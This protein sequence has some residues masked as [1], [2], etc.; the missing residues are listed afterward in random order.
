MLLAFLVGI[1]LAGCATQGQRLDTART[2]IAAAADAITV[3]SKTIKKW[4]ET[5]ISRISSTCP[6][7]PAC[8]SQLAAHDVQFTRAAGIVQTAASSLTQAA[9]TV[10]LVD[11]GVKTLADLAPLLPGLV[12]LGTNLEKTVRAFL[13]APTGG[14]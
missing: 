12:E 7:R 4:D 10:A 11:A 14:K 1:G 3:S 13:D 8:N 6:N 2:V 5:E 9:T